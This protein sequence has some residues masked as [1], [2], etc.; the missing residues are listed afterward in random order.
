MNEITSVLRARSVQT[1]SACGLFPCPS[2][3]RT[4][5]LGV[6]V[7]KMVTA[8]VFLTNQKYGSARLKTTLRIA[9]NLV[10][11]GLFLNPRGSFSVELYLLKILC[12]VSDPSVIKTGCC[13]EDPAVR[14]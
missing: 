3:L 1:S 2:F 9:G 10:D 5:E 6:H 11:I 4:L 13:V 7:C 12:S 8:P 14:S